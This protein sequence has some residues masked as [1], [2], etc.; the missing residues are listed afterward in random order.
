LIFEISKGDALDPFRT[1]CGSLDSD[2]THVLLKQLWKKGS[3][4]QL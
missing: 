4:K 1:A 3:L 2:L